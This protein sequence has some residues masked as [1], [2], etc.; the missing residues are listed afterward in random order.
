MSSGVAHPTA[1]DDDSE[2]GDH[3]AGADASPCA[4][5]FTAT[6]DQRHGVIR[7]RGHLDALAADLLRGSVVALQ[8]QG[9]R[10]VTVRIGPSATMDDDARTVLADLGARLAADGVRLVVE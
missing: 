10:L 6:L 1:A 3:W 8:R 4:P 9:H 5:T 2:P 7:T